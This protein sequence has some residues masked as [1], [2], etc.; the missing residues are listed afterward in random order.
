ME[1]MFSG[2]RA[3]TRYILSL[4]SLPLV[5]REREG[6]PIEFSLSA[7]HLLLGWA[8]NHE[9]RI[10]N[11]EMLDGFLG[12]LRQNTYKFWSLFY[13]AKYISILRSRTGPTRFELA[14]FSV[15]S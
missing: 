8:W 5:G 10:L 9:V 2:P 7:K 15:T 12:L 11:G 13:E 1:I 14:I 6:D 3:S 4:N